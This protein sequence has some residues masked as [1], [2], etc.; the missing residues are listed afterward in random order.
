MTRNSAQQSSTSST[1]HRQ[2]SC[3]QTRDEHDSLVVAMHQLEAALASAA[4]SRERS[5]TEQ[6]HDR[7]RVVAD[8]ITAHVNSAESRDGL[9]AEIESYDPNL[10][11]RTNML[12][13]QHADLLQEA[14]TLKQLVD[15][16][17]KQ[18][19]QDFADVRKVSMRL[20]NALRNHQAAEA[21]LV[22]EAFFTDL[23]VGD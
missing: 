11:F 8:A 13:R 4:P 10:D 21:D 16:Q 20:L 5:W 6:V 15:G 22:F 17:G 3:Q 23:G 7:L 12:R 18:G 2:A 14:Q 19:T 1:E 9:F